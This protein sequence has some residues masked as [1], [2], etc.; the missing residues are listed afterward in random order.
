MKVAIT[1][2]SGFIGSNLSEACLKKGWDVISIDNL[3]GSTDEMAD[4]G[5]VAHLPGHYMF[6]KEDVNNTEKMIEVFKGCDVI[7]HLAARPR[8]SFSTDFPIE[9]HHNNATGTLSV[10]EAARKAKVKRI[11]YSASSSMFGGSGINFPTLE[12]EKT[13]PRSNYALQKFMGLEYCRL[14]SEL[15]GLETCSLI[16]YNVYGPLQRTGPNS[17]YNTVIS[18]FMENA[19]SGKSCRIDGTGSQARD[20]TYV[21]D[22]VKANIMAAEHP[23]PLLGAKFNVAGGNSYSVIDIYDKINALVGGTM[24]KHSAPRRLGDPMK[25]QASTLLAKKVLGYEAE[26]DIYEGLKLTMDWWQ[27]GCP[28]K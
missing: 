12:N 19:L 9:S 15:Y 6:L 16:Y 20:Y 3:C 1:G 21:S 2:S 23:E 27:Q 13:T 7:F 24:K 18:A 14:F 10:L 25:S 26:V 22:I 5:R 17:A 11:V 8:V 4:P 28:V